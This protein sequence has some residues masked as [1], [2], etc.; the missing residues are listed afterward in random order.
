MK[1][2]VNSQSHRL[3]TSRPALVLSLASLA[4]LV[5]CGASRIEGRVV[6]MAHPIESIAIAPGSGEIG[7]GVS[8]GLAD[9]KSFRGRVIDSEQSA[10]LLQQLGIPSP[11][12][13]LPE[14]LPHLREAGVQA[15]LRLESTNALMGS[16]PRTVRVRLTS[17]LTPDQGV[18]FLWHNA[19]GGMPG[20]PA[21]HMAKAGPLKAGQSIA[22]EL[23]RILAELPSA[24]QP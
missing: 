19:W 21:D 20:S 11:K 13:T 15:W 18:E 4:S 22:A 7:E 6:N 2:A 10:A 5:S 8:Q 17:T 9:S 24:S 1:L 12:A 14:N 3:T 16:A 23:A